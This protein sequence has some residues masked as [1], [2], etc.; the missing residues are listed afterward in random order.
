VVPPTPTI[1]IGEIDQT[2]FDCPSCSRPLA[3]GA[4]RCPGCGTRLLRG[5]TLGKAS[6]FIA[7]GLAVGLAVGVGGGAV[8]G[9]SQ[10]VS[11]LVP[12]PAGQSGPITGQNGGG[13]G[14]AASAATAGASTQATPAP[15]V[16]AAIPPLT[17]AALVQVVGTNGRLAAAGTELRAALNARAFDASEVAQ[18]LRAISAES[19][20]SQQVAQHV[21]DWPDSAVLG[22]QLTTFYD[23]VHD[24]A[25]N[26]L[27]ASVQNGAAYRAA[28]RAML[29]LLDGLPALD[30]AVRATAAT[31]GLELPPAIGTTAAP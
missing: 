16:T 1:A 10:A 22:A 7:V 19:V 23:A 8:F 5:V 17:R 3:L 13:T 6:G 4:N 2:I 31:A 20:F 27:V 28:A 26:G 24:T 18:I 11:R 9:L 25:A 12:S 15:T 29:K 21:S 14:P 30:T